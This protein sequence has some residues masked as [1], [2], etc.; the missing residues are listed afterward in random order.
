M[1]FRF[2]RTFLLCILTLSEGVA[3][4]SA[5]PMELTCRLQSAIEPAD[6]TGLTESFRLSIPFDDGREI[7]L[8]DP[9][10]RQIV[11]SP[12]HAEVLAG[13]LAAQGETSTVLWTRSSSSRS[14]LV[15]EVI[16]DD[17]HV[18]VVMVDRAEDTGASRR[19]RIFESATGVVQSGMCA[20]S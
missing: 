5:A 1:T 7:L 20:P 19:L 11:S 12:Y 4:S 14:G 3:V 18:I 6:N 17:G 10:T 16:R 15:G 9:D 8:S 2:V 13:T